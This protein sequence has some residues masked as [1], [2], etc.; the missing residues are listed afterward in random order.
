M[1]GKLFPLY[2]HSL[3]DGAIHSLNHTRNAAVHI[4]GASRREPH[5]NH[6]YEK[7]AVLVYVCVCVCTHVQYTIDAV[8]I[9]SVRLLLV[10]K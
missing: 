7:I 1:E 6:T 2:R 10:S 5:I 4:I 9:V 3:H 8:K